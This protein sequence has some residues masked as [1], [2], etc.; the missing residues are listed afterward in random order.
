M[1]IGV[2][3]KRELA[4]KI[5]TLINA[6]KTTIMM[7]LIFSLFVF[8]VFIGKKLLYIYMYF[9]FES[10]FSGSCHR[11]KPTAIEAANRTQNIISHAEKRSE[12]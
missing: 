8:A 7:S 12:R 4:K 6:S 1:V 11:I 9:Y 2:A 10:H 5:T 3:Y